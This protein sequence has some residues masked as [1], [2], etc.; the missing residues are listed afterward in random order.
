MEEKIN[1]KEVNKRGTKGYKYRKQKTIS[2]ITSA[3]PI[4]LIIA[5]SGKHLM[6][7]SKGRDCQDESKSNIQQYA[8]DKEYTSDS[9]TQIGWK[10]RM[11]N[12]ILGE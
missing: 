12:D 2:K 9:K 3:N 7:W 1:T 8:N 5:L 10:E 4:L 11:E 6:L